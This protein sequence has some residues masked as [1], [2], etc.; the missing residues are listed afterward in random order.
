VRASAAL[1]LLVIAA[2]CR[3][4]QPP[5]AAVIPVDGYE[6]RGTVVSSNGVPLPGVQV[7]LAY[8]AEYYSQTPTDTQVV[9]VTHFSDVVDVAAVDMQ[10]NV[11]KVLFH[12]TFSS[13]G[14]FPRYDWNGIDAAGHEVPSGEYFIRYTVGQSVVKRSPVI[15][16]GNLSATTDANGRFTIDPGHLPV[17]VIFDIYYQSTSFAGAYRILPEVDLY[18]QSQGSS[19]SYLSVTLTTNQVTTGVFVL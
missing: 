8:N 6:L 7:Y 3:D 13:L 17:G 10:D 14:S 2:S 18:F 19:A 9:L 11:R 15:I 5:D 12:G 1:L 16:D 4:I